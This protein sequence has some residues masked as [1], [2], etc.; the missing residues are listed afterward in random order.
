MHLVCDKQL[1]IDIIKR[2]EEVYRD[3][4]QDISPIFQSYALNIVL[5]LKLYDNH[6]AVSKRFDIK[7]GTCGHR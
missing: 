1:M 3:W 6:I 7:M 2:L 4:Y 5:R